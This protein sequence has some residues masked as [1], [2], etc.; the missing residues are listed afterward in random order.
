MEFFVKNLQSY[1]SDY[2]LRQFLN[3]GIS[4]LYFFDRKKDDSEV[5]KYINNLNQHAIIAY[6]QLDFL[7][8]TVSKISTMLNLR[9]S[10]DSL[11]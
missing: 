5:A 9:A 6:R 2:W 10:N 8:L 11:Q 1:F 4:I 3:Y 7:T